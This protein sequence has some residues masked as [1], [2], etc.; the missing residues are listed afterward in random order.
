MAYLSFAEYDRIENIYDKYDKY[1]IIVGLLK[2]V[3][4]PADKDFPEDYVFWCMDPG[5]SMYGW[6]RYVNFSTMFPNKLIARVTL[7]RLRLFPASSNGWK[8]VRSAN[9]VRIFSVDHPLVQKYI[10]DF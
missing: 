2:I 10:M 3:P 5:E 1:C 4:T 6:T 7:H 9:N 8:N